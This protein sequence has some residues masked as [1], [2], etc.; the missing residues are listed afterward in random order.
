MHKK[1]VARKKARRKKEKQ[2]KQQAKEKENIKKVKDQVE[3]DA[4]DKLE[5]EMEYTKRE[6]ERK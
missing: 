2:E 5:L 6:I 4:L 1:L 3:N